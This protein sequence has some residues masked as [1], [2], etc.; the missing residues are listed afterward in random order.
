MNIFLAH[1]SEFV[2]EKNPC[3][4]LKSLE[5]Y[6]EEFKNEIDT[7]FSEPHCSN[8][9]PTRRVLTFYKLLESKF[10]HNLNRFFFHPCL[11]KFEIY[12]FGIDKSGDDFNLDTLCIKSNTCSKYH[13][14]WESCE[15]VQHYIKMGM[16]ALMV[17]DILKTNAPFDE[18]KM[19]N[20]YFSREYYPYFDT[21]Y[22]IIVTGGLGT[23][24]PKDIID[25]KTA[26][27]IKFFKKKSNDD[28]DNFAKL[29]I[30]N[31]MTILALISILNNNGFN[32]PLDLYIS[33]NLAAMGMLHDDF[34]RSFVPDIHHIYRFQEN[35]SKNNI[36]NNKK[37]RFIIPRELVIKKILD[38]LNDVYN[39]VWF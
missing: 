18:D 21:F 38:I 9:F 17:L 25:D 3:E 11:N 16:V 13:R 15:N 36:Y 2:F 10:I 8:T 4:E 31:I 29:W 23:S 12:Q 32:I 6:P 22:T 33:A 24:D 14:E 26:Y 39:S 28:D 7:F 19:L 30:M 37:Y 34:F 20:T 5:L 35:Y 27:L 1:E